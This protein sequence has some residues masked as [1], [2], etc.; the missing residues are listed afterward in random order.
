MSVNIILNNLEFRNKDLLKKK[1][2]KKKDLYIT[3]GHI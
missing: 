3:K 2:K 1:K